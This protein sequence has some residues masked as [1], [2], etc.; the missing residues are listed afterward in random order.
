MVSGRRCNIH[1]YTH[2]HGSAGDVYGHAH[3]HIDANGDRYVH[4]H[5]G[6]LKHSH[7]DPRADRDAKPNCDASANGDAGARDLSLPEAQRERHV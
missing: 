1:T 2:W 3:Q 6:T 4:E 5:R 7:A